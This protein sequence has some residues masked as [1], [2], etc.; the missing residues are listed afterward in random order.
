MGFSPPLT[1]ALVAMI[2]SAPIAS[3]GGWDPTRSHH[4]DLVQWEGGIDRGRV[5]CHMGRNGSGGCM[6]EANCVLPVGRD[7]RENC[8]LHNLERHG[9]G[10][11]SRSW[12][13][14]TYAC[15][16]CNTSLFSSA[17]KFDD[18]D[19]RTIHFLNSTRILLRVPRHFPPVGLLLCFPDLHILSRHIAGHGFATFTK[20]ITMGVVG[21]RDHEASNT[22]AT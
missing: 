18:G 5:G 11:Y 15:S 19:K 7:L 6:T 3:S 14:A 22:Y 10:R 1:L 2:T 12:A 4:D 16:C 9:L 13:K 17:D 21:Y 8:M 20:P